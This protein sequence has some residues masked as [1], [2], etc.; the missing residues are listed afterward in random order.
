MEQSIM[1]GMQIIGAETS[2]CSKRT[3][4]AHNPGTGESLPTSF[5]QATRGEIHHAALLADE[6]FDPFRAKAPNGV[7]AFLFAIADQIE[8]LGDELWE[9]AHAE[10]GLT[11][12]QLVN[13]ARRTVQQTRMFAQLVRDGSWLNARIDPG[14]KDP[15]PNPRPDLRTTLFPLGP[16]AVFGAS[17]LPL[18]M[19]VAGTDTISALAAACPVIAKAHPLH[20]GTCELLGMAMIEAARQTAMPSGVFSMIHTTNAEDAQYLVQHP[21][22]QAVAFTGTYKAGNALLQAANSRPDPIPVFAGMGSVNP[23]FLLP[24]ILQQRAGEIAADFVHSVTMNCGQSCTRPGIVVGLKSNE[25]HEFIEGAVRFAR[26]TPKQLMLSESVY[27]A[28]DAG[29]QR[30]AQTSGVEALTPLPESGDRAGSGHASLFRSCLLFQ[31]KAKKFLA[32]A[33]LHEDL[34]GPAALIV[35]CET[36]EEL[37]AVARNLTGQLSAA[38]FGTH[39][40]L[41]EYPGL[42]RELKK[43]V[44][45]IVFNEL[46]TEITVSHAIHHGGPFPA[47]TLPQFSSM[48]AGAIFRFVRPLCFQNCPDEMLPAELQNGNPRGLWRM[49]DGSFT[50]QPCE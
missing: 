10:T 12:P 29:V 33:H 41:R 7:A 44:G 3:F 27:L 34:F 28:F 9:R 1:H 6:A 8:K 25:F 26:E 49:V 13:E 22:I 2:A 18:S 38:V 4:T 35:C 48:G 16:V 37:F 19:S 23:V 42:L 11:I 32:E 15:V 21:L 30:M 46:P 31:T 47:A 39:N 40:D 24:D 50:R 20:P 45:R 17:S 14:Q 43:R 5:H 36:E